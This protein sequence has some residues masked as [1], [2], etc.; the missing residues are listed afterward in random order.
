MSG[1]NNKLVIFLAFANDRD[2][3]L[4]YLRNLPDETRR[5]REVLKP[6]EEAS[7]CE[8]VVRSNCTAEDIIKVFQDPQYRNRI[9]I[10]HFGG[11]A[12]GYQLLLESASG[13]AAAASAGGFAAFLAQ[14]RGM[15]L[16]FLN[17]CS[18]QEQTRGLLNA[19][20][21]AVIST[22]RSIDDKVATDFAFHFYQGLA[23]GAT[24]QTAYKEAE[25]SVQ[26]SKGDNTRE[27]WVENMDGLQD[28]TET[29]RWPW[30]LILSEDA[31]GAGLWNLPQA[32]DDPLFGLPPLPQQD[33][34]E[35]PY[36]YLDWF[37]RK[38]A[39]VFFGRG[40]QIRELYDRL[41]APHSAPIL[42][43]YGQSGVGKSSILDAGLIPRLERDHEV[44]YLRRSGKGLL[45]TLQSAF[46]ADVTQKGLDE[47]WREQEE[48]SGRPLI[49]FLD[50]VE[51][52]FT[53]PLAEIPDEMLQFILTLKIIFD[54]PGRRPKGKLV[55]GFRKEWLAE[56]EDKLA[57]HE[58]PRSKVFLQPLDRRG[59]IEVVRGP[60]GSKRLRDQ[61]GLS[62]GEELPEIIADDLTEDRDSAIAPTL[63]ILLTKLWTKAKEDNYEQPEFTQALYQQLKRDGILLGDFLDQQIAAFHEKYPEAVNSGLLLDIMA[64]HTTAL[65][66][67]GHCDKTVLEQQYAHIDAS[68]T[69]LIQQCQD[70]H[71]LTVAAGFNKESDK[72]TRLAHD[73]LAPL[74]RE[75]YDKSDKPGQRARRILDN[76]SV[77]WTSEQNGTPLDEADLEVVRLGLKGTHNLN[78]AEKRLVEASEQQHRKQLRQRR[79]RKLAAVVAVIAISLA[80]AYGWYQRGVAEKLGRVSVARQLAIESALADDSGR[81]KDSLLLA[82]QSLQATRID[83]VLVAEA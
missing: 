12:N 19:N 21:P 5:L 64:M 20:I 81:S 10:F 52:V 3:S 6:A 25:A 60:T 32:A 39:E 43:F 80:G 82:I 35:S 77:D 14:Q 16:V 18:T 57:S 61:Y 26:T 33:L 53:R 30:D 34:P 42:L 4:R 59:V 1:K 2:N 40:M 29:D 74:V 58:L 9:A 67:A 13:Q 49:V 37:T 65:G 54:D 47:A 31:G 17:G 83:D 78:G 8:L 70:L 62:I 15:Q 73:T 23:G 50:Q 56:L 55:L 71:L 76:R 75:R 44:R 24:I 68:L 27:A 22:S 36:R 45:E 38:D 48:K 72:V 11:H 79:G 63:Q 7:L 51:E 69:A 46:S 41:T 28:L 66:T